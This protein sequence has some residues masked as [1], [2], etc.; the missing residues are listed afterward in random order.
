MLLTYSTCMGRLPMHVR[1]S[2]WVAVTV[3]EKLAPLTIS[4]GTADVPTF[5]PELTVVLSVISSGS[6]GSFEIWSCRQPRCIASA[7]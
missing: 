6:S 7:S 1:V 5:E 3:N 2:G 4:G